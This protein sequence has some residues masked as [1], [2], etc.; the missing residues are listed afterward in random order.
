M[1]IHQPVAGQSSAP[2]SKANANMM[3]NVLVLVSMVRVNG[4]ASTCS[5]VGATQTSLSAA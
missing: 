1:T 3:S 2:S 4:T 5:P